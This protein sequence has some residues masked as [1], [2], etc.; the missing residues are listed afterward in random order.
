MVKPNLKVLGPKLGKRL[1]ALQAALKEADAAAIVA[2]V[3][4][5][6]AAVVKL[7]DGELR[8]VEEELLVET[9]SPE[10]Y[11]VESDAGRVVALKTEVDEALREE[12]LARELVHAVQLARKTADLR[13]EDTISLTLDVPEQLRPPAERH[14]AAIMAETLASAF[15]LGEAAR[16]PPRDGPGRRSR[17][18]YRTQRDGYHLHRHLRLTRGGTGPAASGRGRRRRETPWNRCVTRRSTCSS[19]WLGRHRTTPCS[20]T[21]RGPA[22][23]G[24]PWPPTW[25]T[26][27]AADE[28]PDMLEEG[29]RLAS[30]LGLVNVAF[31]LVDLYALPYK[32]GTFSL[33]VCRNA[34]HLLPDPATALA[35]LQRVLSPGGRVVIL[36]AVVDEVT[37]KAFNEIARLREP[38]HRR[39]YRQ[40]EFE[41]LVERAGFVVRSR[42]RLRSTID[43]DYWLQAAAVPP[44]RRTSSAAASRSCRSRSRRAWTWP[45]PTGS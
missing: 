32:D 27:E 11:Q 44:P 6:G 45:S 15:A 4:G 3:R 2:A 18:R 12:G 34:F 1:G 28:L 7:P 22:W 43:L 39:H 41:A 23:P 5:G 31:T 42:G 14:R 25:R 29:K 8:L 30:E 36:D 10:G 35:E 16:R 38:A 19:S 37:D 13:I 24:S 9:G 33:V 17:G 21:P 26:V 20:T 40:D